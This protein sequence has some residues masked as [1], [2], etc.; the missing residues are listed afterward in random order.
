MNGAARERIDAMGQVL[1]W[2]T[3]V[4]I[5]SIGFLA[6]GKLDSIDEK[7]RHQEERSY[8]LEHKFDDKLDSLS[9]FASEQKGLLQ[10]VARDVIRNEARLDSHSNRIREIEISGSPAH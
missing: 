8:E 3:P 7:Q 6:S 9:A 5:V 1:R 2:I 4:M 10:S